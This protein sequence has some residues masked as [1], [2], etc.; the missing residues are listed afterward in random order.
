MVLS[1]CVSHHTCCASELN[2]I[3]ENPA[4]S[5]NSRRPLKHMDSH[6]SHDYEDV[7]SVRVICCIES[8]PVS[9]LDE[10]FYV[11]TDVLCYRESG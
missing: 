8:V 2:Q 1:N 5:W 11:S 9:L 3:T 10:W 7:S 6:H 4:G